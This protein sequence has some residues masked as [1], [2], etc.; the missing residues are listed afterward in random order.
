MFTVEA[1]GNW[2][3]SAKDHFPQDAEKTKCAAKVYGPLYPNRDDGYL[4]P[5]LCVDQYYT[6]EA[7]AYE[8]LAEF[9][10]NSIPRFFESYSLDR[11]VR[12]GLREIIARLD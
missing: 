2:N 5:F 10:G 8:L 3:S 7:C 12:D 6:H 9:Q 11:T 4:N 1:L